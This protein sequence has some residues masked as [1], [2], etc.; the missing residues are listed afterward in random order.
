MLSAVVDNIYAQDF[1]SRVLVTAPIKPSLWLH[2]VDDTFVMWNH[3]DSELQNFLK[4]LNGQHD[5]ICFT[6]ERE[7]DGTI[8]FLDV[9]VKRDGDQL[10]TS[11]HRKST[12]TDCYLNYSSHHHIEVKSGNVDCL[13]HRVKRICTKGF[14]LSDEM[15]YPIALMANGYLRHTL[16]RRWKERRQD[17]PGTGHPKARMFLP[18]IKGLSER[19]G[20]MCRPLGIHTTFTSRNTL[21]KFHRKSLMKVKGKPGML[22]EKGV[23]YSIP[24]A[25]CLATYMGETGKTLKVHMAEHKREVKRKDPLNGIAVHVQKTAHNINWQEAWIHL[26]KKNGPRG[27]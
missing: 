10:T 7:D 9:R 25:D 5:N 3:E 1:E 16:K 22:D 13:S 20:R 14:A 2:Y 6:V 19:I 12:H 27:P 4:H 21:R 8:L 18:Y 17:G 15:H 26:G 23:V 11:V 24:C